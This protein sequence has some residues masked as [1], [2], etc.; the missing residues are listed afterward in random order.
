MH[1]I[2][3]NLSKVLALT[4]MVSSFAILPGAK[5]SGT[6]PENIPQLQNGRSRTQ[7]ITDGMINQ[8]IADLN[9]RLG[10][11]DVV[12][13]SPAF[14]SNRP[15]AYKI[16]QELISC[17][18]IQYR[19]GLPAFTAKCRDKFIKSGKKLYLKSLSEASDALLKL[20]GRQRA[21]A[22]LTIGDTPTLDVPSE[23]IT[24]N[25]ITMF[26]NWPN[27]RDGFWSCENATCSHRH[28]VSCSLAYITT[29]AFDCFMEIF[30][31][32]GSIPFAAGASIGG[33]CGLIPVRK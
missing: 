10:G 26:F 7:V 30:V 27:Q 23:D 20:C 1:S 2:I 32:T 12:R 21:Y 33:G 15:V 4:T 17:F 6:E 28:C 8:A 24:P 3:K 25:A 22:S 16:L 18:E 29:C 11:T 5:A 31:R 9:E 13:C 19:G 14:L